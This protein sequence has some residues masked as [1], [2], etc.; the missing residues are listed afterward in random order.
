MSLSYRTTDWWNARTARPRARHRPRSARA[1]PPGT[2]VPG[3]ESEQQ[4]LE[5]VLPALTEVSEACDNRT[6]VV[7]THSAVIR[8]VL[9]RIA[10]GVADSTAIPIDPASVH[11]FRWVGG[12]P[13]GGCSDSADPVTPVAAGIPL[14]QF[15]RGESDRRSPQEVAYELTE[16]G[17]EGREGLLD[18]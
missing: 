12:R 5:R 2:T 13:Y 10:P 18:A 11:T 16:H 17:V 6:V 14:Q 4:I 1:F 9:R 15:I 8:A 7:V 3:K